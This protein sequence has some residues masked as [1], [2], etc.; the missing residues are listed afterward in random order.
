MK[1]DPDALCAVGFVLDYLKDGPA[2]IDDLYE[3]GAKQ[4][5]FT[6]CDV[7]EAGRHLG[8]LGKKLDGVSYVMRP[9][10]LLAIWWAKRSHVPRSSERR[11]APDQ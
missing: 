10:N 7:A 2:R 8:L 4:F 9:H 11:A 6:R 5:G 3:V 1:R